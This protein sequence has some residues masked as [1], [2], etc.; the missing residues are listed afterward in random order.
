MHL[1]IKNHVTLEFTC[2]AFDGFIAS[3]SNRMSM[4]DKRLIKKA[5]KHLMASINNDLGKLKVLLLDENTDT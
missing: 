3:I 5:M 2:K 1:R 4:V